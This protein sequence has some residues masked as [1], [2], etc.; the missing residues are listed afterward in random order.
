MLVAI[1][2]WQLKDSSP[3]LSGAGRLLPNN[4][5]L[6]AQ[7]CCDPGYLLIMSSLDKSPSTTRKKE[8]CYTS[9][10]LPGCCTVRGHVHDREKVNYCAVPPWRHTNFSMTRSVSFVRLM[11]STTA[12]SVTSGNTIPSFL[13]S[14]Y[15]PMIFPVDQ[16]PRL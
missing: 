3:A 14:S 2:Y 1:T 4:F 10:P 9:W 13:P 8:L 7:K 5:L 15:L 12:F 6:F 16:R 11:P